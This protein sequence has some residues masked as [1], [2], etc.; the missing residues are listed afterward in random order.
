ML[1]KT[2]KFTALS[3][4]FFSVNAYAADT[5]NLTVQLS[6]FSNDKGV[7]RVALFNSA[8]TFQNTNEQTATPFAKA[9]APISN[10]SATVTFNQIPYGTYAIKTFHDQNM[11]GVIPKGAFGKPA[12]DYGFSN[13]PTIHFSAP[14]F[15]QTQFMVNSPDTTIQITMNQ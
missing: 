8:E 9:S 4:F 2:L 1:N 3:A 12:T 13:N 7:V 14:T 6:N 15:A 5:G 11:S 10:N